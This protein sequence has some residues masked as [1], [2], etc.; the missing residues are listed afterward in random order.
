MAI[1]HYSTSKYKYLHDRIDNP[2]HWVKCG[3]PLWVSETERV[4]HY[5]LDH[6][7]PVMS[8]HREILTLEKN[9]VSDNPREV[10]CLQCLA[11][12]W[13]ENTEVP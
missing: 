7:Q 13:P 6:F 5:K 12:P 1:T 4:R 2:L 11:L 3:V 10:T 8:L 9:S